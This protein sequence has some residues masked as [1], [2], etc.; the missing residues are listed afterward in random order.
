[1]Q[2]KTFL[3]KPLEVKR[4]WHLIDA[5]GLV[6]GQVA[7]DIAK[8][9]LGKDKTT[10]TPNVDGGDYVVV[11]NAE[12][13]EVT[14]TKSQKKMYYN[15]SSLPG[16]I[17]GRSFAEVQEKKPEEVIERAV[18]NMLPANRLRKDRMSRLKIHKGAEHKYQAEI[19]GK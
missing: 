10:F 19:Y 5:K 7:T 8:K 18:Y 16:G 4:T 14:R 6:L 17:R 3:Q 9:L 13:V 15:H 1:M 11:I 2:K 12:L